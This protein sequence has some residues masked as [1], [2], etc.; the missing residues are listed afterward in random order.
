VEEVAA[1]PRFGDKASFMI[2]THPGPGG[3]SSSSM[4]P[5]RPFLS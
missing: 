3:A 5:Q 4:R 2:P 1:R